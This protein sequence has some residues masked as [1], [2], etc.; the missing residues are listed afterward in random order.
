MK[1]TELQ[2]CGLLGR[3]CEYDLGEGDGGTIL[4]KGD[5]RGRGML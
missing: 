2:R 3:G 1:G 4:G 5:V